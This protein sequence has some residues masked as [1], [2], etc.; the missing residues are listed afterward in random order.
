M[1][2]DR[3]QRFLYGVANLLGGI[4]LFLALIIPGGPLVPILSLAGLAVLVFVVAISLS[5]WK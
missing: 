1:A 4:V 2:I 3:V 5:L